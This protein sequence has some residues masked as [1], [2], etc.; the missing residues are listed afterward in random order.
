MKKLTGERKQDKYGRWY[1]QTDSGRYYDT[2][3]TTK[4][5][6]EGFHTHGGSKHGRR[7]D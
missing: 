4:I 1:T 7:D 3:C 5:V 6:G 2:I